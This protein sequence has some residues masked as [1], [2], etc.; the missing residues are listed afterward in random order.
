[1][2]LVL[3]VLVLIMLLAERQLPADGE[4]IDLLVLA[5]VDGMPVE[6]PRPIVEGAWS[7]D[8]E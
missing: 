8:L 1:M 7:L 6:I 3:L 5:L 4:A 2:L